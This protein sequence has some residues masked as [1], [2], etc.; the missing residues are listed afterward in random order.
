[1]NFSAI[2]QAQL[3]SHELRAQPRQNESAHPLSAAKKQGAHSGRNDIDSAHSLLERIQ[4]IRSESS[5]N[6][7]CSNMGNHHEVSPSALESGL[8]NEKSD[9]LSILTPPTT[10]TTTKS[11]DGSQKWL[12]GTYTHSF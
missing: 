2:G 12:I 10:P 8:G 4:I 6:F 5:L 7:E 11:S 3:E 1:M 9:A